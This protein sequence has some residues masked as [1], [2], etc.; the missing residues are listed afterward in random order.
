MFYFLT[1]RNSFHSIFLRSRYLQTQMKSQAK[2]EVDEK[3][4]SLVGKGWAGVEWREG[5]RKGVDVRI[6]GKGG[7]EDGELKGGGE[8]WRDEA[9]R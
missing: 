1:H 5:G 4:L 6:G 7:E 8:S 2:W 3:I 9:G